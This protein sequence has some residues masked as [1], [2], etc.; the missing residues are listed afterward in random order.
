LT[1]LLVGRQEFF[2]GAMMVYAVAN[3]FIGA[4]P[5]A[6]AADVMPQS[7]SGFGLGMFRCAGDIGAYC[8]LARIKHDI[9]TI[10]TCLSKPYR[11][12]VR[13]SSVPI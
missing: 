9:I 2:V 10:I 11:A 4:T 12:Q 6:F 13:R 5:A 8:H 1:L 3:S 7:V